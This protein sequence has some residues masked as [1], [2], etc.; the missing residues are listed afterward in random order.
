VRPGYDGWPVLP[1]GVG[2]EDYCLVSSAEISFPAGDPL[3]QLADLPVLPS[4]TI[5]RFASGSGDFLLVEP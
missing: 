4:G 1:G 2:P 5:S 3:D